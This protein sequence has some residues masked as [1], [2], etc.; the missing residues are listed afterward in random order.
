MSA[1][2]C[3][4]LLLALHPISEFP[5]ECQTVSAWMGENGCF[6][7]EFERRTPAPFNWITAFYD[8]ESQNWLDDSTGCI[9]E[10]I[11]HWLD[12]LPPLEESDDESGVSG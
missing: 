9:V 6:V 11:T 1:R 2:I 5:A 7:D 3:E 4:S 12:P 8:A 10:G